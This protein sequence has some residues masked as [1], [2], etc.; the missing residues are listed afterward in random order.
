MGEF[1]AAL[2]HTQHGVLEL[3]KTDRRSE[4]PSALAYLNYGHSSIPR[5]HIGQEGEKKG[6]A[7]QNRMDA[8]TPYFCTDDG[9]LDIVSFCHTANEDLSWFVG[10]V[11]E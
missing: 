1:G 6:G 2:P 8:Y 10:A 7:S 9:P 3:T 11:V 5:Q 4:T